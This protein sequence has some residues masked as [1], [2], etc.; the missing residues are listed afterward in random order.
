VRNS[1][2]PGMPGVT[3]YLDLNKDGKLESGEPTQV[4]NSF[5]SYKF[6]GLL[7]GAYRVREIPPAQYVQTAPA[8]KFYDLTLKPGANVTGKLFG[9]AHAAASIS[10]RVFG[11]SNGNGVRDPGEV[12]MGLWKV[13]VDLNKDGVLDGNDLS[14]TTDFFG[15]WSFGGLTKGTYLIRVVPVDGLAATTAT[16][17]T[18]TVGDGQVSTGSL[19]GER[20]TT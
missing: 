2:E 16:V 8:A 20:A 3:V 10:G 4:T 9:N 19:F 12:G 14:T 5:G 13:F 15:K 7:A 1:G 18:V 11:D 6:S 17:L